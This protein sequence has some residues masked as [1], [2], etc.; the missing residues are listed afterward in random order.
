MEN[1]SS[2]K[3]IGIVIVVIIII[4]G[5][6]LMMRKPTDTTVPA[7]NNGAYTSQSSDQT[8]GDTSALQSSGSSNADLAADSASIDA[9]MQ[10]LSSDN[11]SAN[12]AVQ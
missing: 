1:T 5:I 11:A 7:A 8:Q 4:V 6:W 2:S 3:T 10:G 12:Q 9:Q